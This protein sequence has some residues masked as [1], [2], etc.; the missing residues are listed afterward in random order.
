MF[1]KL[2]HHLKWV[3]SC[4]LLFIVSLD[5]LE[6]LKWDNSIVSFL[7]F[8]I[9]MF[10][11]ENNGLFLWL[12]HLSDWEQELEFGFMTLFYCWTLAVICGRALTLF[13]YQSQWLTAALVFLLSYRDTAACHLWFLIRI[14]RSRSLWWIRAI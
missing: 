12:D 3:A 14:K 1:Y 6:M 9:K 7:F 10:I 11:L 13:V 8:S 5:T 2:F 4:L